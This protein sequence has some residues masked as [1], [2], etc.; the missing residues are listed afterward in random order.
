M[1]RHLES[2]TGSDQERQEQEIAALGPWFHNLHLPSGVE[3]A[4]SHFLGDFPRYKWHALAPH[5]PQRLDGWSALDIG[6]NAGYYSFELARRGAQVT[7]IDVDPHYLRQAEWAAR[8]LGLENEIE[9][10]QLQGY[11]LAADDQTW[12]LVVFMRVV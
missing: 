3:T 8:E 9:F 10:R 11:E 5:I 4:P 1:S 2:P 7:G 12:A 6:C